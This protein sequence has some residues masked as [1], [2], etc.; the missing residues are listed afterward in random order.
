M[1]SLIYRLVASRTDQERNYEMDGS[2][3]DN[4]DGKLRRE[5]PPMLCIKNGFYR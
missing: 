4:R 5:I 1:A 2:M 3:H